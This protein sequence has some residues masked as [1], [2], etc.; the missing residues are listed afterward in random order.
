MKKAL[1]ITSDRFPSN[2]A[3]ATRLGIFAK[4]LTKNDYSVDIV[5]LYRK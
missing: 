3:G 5:S 1:L 2:N 4:L